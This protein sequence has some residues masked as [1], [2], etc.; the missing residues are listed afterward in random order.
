MTKVKINW[1]TDAITFYKFVCKDATILYTYAGHTT[2]FRHRKTGHKTACNNPTDRAYNLPLYQ[3]IRTNGGWSN[4]NMRVIKTQICKDK[5]EA[6]Q[7]ETEL[8]DEQAFKL[9]A[10][11]AYISKEDIKAHGAIYY[12]EHNEE[13]KA[14]NAKYKQ[15]HKEKYNSYNTTYR[16]ENREV[17]NANRREKYAQRKA[18]EQSVK[19]AGV[20][21]PSTE[22]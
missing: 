7:I 8:I 1:E 16:Q 20:E 15:E 12:Q 9:N 21:T 17:I 14:Y 6:R 4:W 19:T 11:R 2:S 13:I 10:Y 18:Q 3:F 22:L 5:L